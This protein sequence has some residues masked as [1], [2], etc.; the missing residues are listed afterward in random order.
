MYF[1][2][3]RSIFTKV[4]KKKKKEEA[5]PQGQ[6]LAK[7]TC[8]GGQNEQAKKNVIEKEKRAMQAGSGGH[9]GRVEKQLGLNLQVSGGRLRLYRDLG[10]L[11]SN[12]FN[13]KSKHELTGDTKGT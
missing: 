1:P 7:R 4:N 6:A 5:E 8:R 9:I 11:M 2:L 13:E 12:G 3:L 10:L